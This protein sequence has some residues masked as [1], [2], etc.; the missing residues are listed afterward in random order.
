MNEGLSFDSLYGPKWPI[1]LTDEEW[2]RA[3]DQ[4]LE[5]DRM[6]KHSQEMLEC[7]LYARVALDGANVIRRRRGEAAILVPTSIVHEPPFLHLMWPFEMEMV[8]CLKIAAEAL[9]K[10]PTDSSYRP[11]LRVRLTSLQCSRGIL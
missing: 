1:T 6:R 9:A 8:P 2:A 7:R 3:V 11:R 5:Q 4:K 10:Y